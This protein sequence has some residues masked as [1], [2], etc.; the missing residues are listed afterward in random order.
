MRGSIVKRG[1]NSWAVVVY[2]G[3][4]PGTGKPKQKWFSHKTRR[5]AEVHLSQLLSQLHG[6]AVLPD[7]K[8][9]VVEFLKQ[10]LRDYA[11]TNVALTTQAIYEE[12][13]R[14][15]L[16][17]ALGPLPLQR[18]SPQTIQS[19]LRAKI[20]A[21]LSAATVHKVYRVLR[22]ALGH[23]VKWGL[24][25]RNPCEFVDPPRIRRGD[26]RV[27]DEEQVRLFLGEAK[28]SS[29][30]YPLYLMALL[31]G[32]RLGELLGL[33]WQDVDQLTGRVSVQQILY[34]LGKRVI[35]KEPKSAK[36][37]RTIPLS[38]ILI[39]ELGHMRSQREENRRLFG[40]RYADHGLVFCQPDGK[41]LHGHN[42]TQ[43][44]FRMVLSRAGL[45]HMR[46][47]DLRHSHATHLL[48]QGVHPKVIQER[49]GHSSP[50]FTMAVYTHVLP[51]MQEEAVLALETRLLG[52]K[53]AAH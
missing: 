17:P 13:V 16:T 7:T 25:S 28:R 19:L 31:T 35:L 5:E 30:Y 10:W 14:V 46:F 33:R 50:A 15:H 3:R 32:M 44:D 47:H 9:R 11:G 37:R 53:E 6:G 43:R 41:P 49:L 26:M 4:D 12:V 2:V 24:L 1:Q 21:G 48:R 34:R 42:V 27:L 23:A 22:E 40:A 51:G 36:A 29:R 39:E 18:L 52:H 45:P 8:I 38:P 20:D